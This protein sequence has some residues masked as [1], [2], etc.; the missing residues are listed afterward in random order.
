MP[1]VEHLREKVTQSGPRSIEAEAH[2][3]DWATTNWT[4][5]KDS[6][7]GVTRQRYGKRVAW[8]F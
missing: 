6:K 2:K 7:D 1:F 5:L 8:A 4:E 3:L